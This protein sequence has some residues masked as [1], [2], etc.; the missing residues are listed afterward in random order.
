VVNFGA[1]IESLNI[2]INGL[3][4]NVQ[5]YGYVKT[6]LTSTNVMDENSFLEPNK[7]VP[8]TS[9]LEKVGKDINVILSPYSVTSLDLL[10]DYNMVTP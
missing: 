10:Y 5:Q 7:V 3:N 1:T 4:S 2:T 8:Q 9:S 6:V